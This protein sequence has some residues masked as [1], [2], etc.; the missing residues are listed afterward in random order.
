MIGLD[1]N[2]LL[3]SVL[4]DDPQQSRRANAIFDS[5]TVDEPGWV[6][7]TNLIEMVWVLTRMVH[8][9]RGVVSRI[10]NNVLALDTIVLEQPG[11]VARA[12][13]RYS[14]GKAD[15]ADCVIAV[16]AEAAGCTKTL[17]FDRIAARDAGMELIR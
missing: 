4:N 5:L 13:E 6:G 8:L 1:T 11:I 2:V 14:R 10:V 9:D 15:F 3:R 12:L 16:S 17:T 7:L